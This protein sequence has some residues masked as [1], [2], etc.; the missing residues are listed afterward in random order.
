MQE[1][2]LKEKRWTKEIEKEIYSEWKK[3]NSYKFNKNTKK[4]VY[5]IDTPPPYVNRPVHIGQVTT[6]VLM[7]C[8]AR[9]KRMKGFEV[10]FPLGLDNN[11]LPIEM[12]AE[13]KFK[14]SP[15]KVSR[16]EYLKKCKEMLDKSGLESLES[17]LRSG[18]SF[19]SW[20]IGKEL[21]EIYET[22]SPDYRSLTQDTFIDLWNK[23]LIYEA[24]RINNY[25]PGCRTTLADAE[26]DYEDI[27]SNFN[28]VTFKI[29]ETGEEI[30]IGTT[31]PELIATCG[32][33]IFNPDDDRY[34]KLDG[35][36]VITPIYN[37]EVPIMSHPLAQLEKGTGLVMMCSIG[38]LSDI[39]FFREQNITPII[40]IGQDGRMNEHAGLLKG[41]KVKEAREKIIYYLIFKKKKVTE[42]PVQQMQQTIQPGQPQPQMQ[43]PTQEPSAPA[44]TT[45]PPQPQPSPQPQPQPQPQPATIQSR[46][47]LKF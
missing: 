26:V 35:K 42:M 10:L 27:P 41:L 22:D 15:G 30:I 20:K 21:G 3:K 24:A 17:F 18:I 38:D 1:A 11:G 4:K 12:E 29:K 46:Y 34:Q 9:Y 47:K 28:D 14:I 32:A 37:K 45:P 23:G 16:E 31:R 7:D 2:K 43:Q 25:C 36:T 5:S 13:R 40:A 19:N 33:V 6:Y 8:F 44:P 39:R